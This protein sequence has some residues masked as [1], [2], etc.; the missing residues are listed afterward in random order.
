MTADLIR[1][2]VGISGAR[3]WV[4]ALLLMGLCISTA[5]DS[6]GART[7]AE[8]SAPA[9]VRITGWLKEGDERPFVQ[10][11]GFFVA[12]DGMVLSVTNAFTEIPT[13]LMCERLDV[14]LFDGRR[15]RA[16]VRAADALLNL[17]L[18]E[19]ENSDGGSPVLEPTSRVAQLDEPVIA[20]AA[21]QGDAG[22]IAFAAGQV[23]TQRRRSVY[24]AGLGDMLIDLELDPPPGADGGP[25]LDEFGKVI[26]IMT[27]NIH[28]SLDVPATPGEAHALPMRTATGFIKISTSRPLSDMTWVG[29]AFRPLSPDQADATA[30]LLG[31]RAGV[32]VDFVWRDGPVGTSDIRTGDILVALDGKDMPDLFRLEQ[33][34]DA[35][36]VGDRPE[37]ALLRDGRLV[38]RQL[39]VE[40]R[41]R[42]AGFVPWRFN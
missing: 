19:V 41:P 40:K 21:G 38:F 35:A 10:T 12:A 32:F 18:V 2:V 23:K 5:A 28:R 15:L 34:L 24:G 37:A 7:I 25:L 20:V 1:L 22:R 42:W 26:G 30:K 33:R 9:V 6:G 31:R 16:H 17:I 29:L 4:T 3:H 27:P 14:R 11:S 36:A 8:Q 39:A 13:R